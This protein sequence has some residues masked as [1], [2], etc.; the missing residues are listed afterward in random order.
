M[1]CNRY[2]RYISYL[3]TL[4][5][6]GDKIQYARYLIQAICQKPVCVVFFLFSCNVHVRSDESLRMLLSPAL[7]RRKL[8][9]GRPGKKTP[10]DQRGGTRDGL[11]RGILREGRFLTIGS[12]V[13]GELLTC[14]PNILLCFTR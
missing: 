11:D 5:I 14:I 13:R 2:I 12:L 7:A 9:L 8:S 3:S 6:N 4:G 10:Y 1:D